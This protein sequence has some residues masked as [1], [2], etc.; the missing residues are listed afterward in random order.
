MSVNKSFSWC[1]VASLSAYYSPVIRGQLT[2][3]V[4]VSL[5]FSILLLLD[6]GEMAQVCIFTLSWTIIP[7]MFVFA[8]LAFVRT[9]DTRIIE[10]MIPASALEKFIFY[11]VYLLIVVPVAVYALPEL[12]ILLYT[13]IPAIQTP[14]VMELVSL[15]CNGFCKILFVNLLSAIAAS[16]TCLY[17]V[18]SARTSRIIKGI[19]SVFGVQV[20]IGILG[21]F[22]GF[23]AAFRQFKAGVKDGMRGDLS[24]IDEIPRAD[25]QTILQDMNDNISYVLVVLGILTV[26]CLL[27]LW[28]N[29]RGLKKRNL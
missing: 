24:Q 6:V 8:P 4:A 9:G 25:V 16:V 7:F 21:A 23:S 14:G 20:A 17:V 10:R 5:M 26:Y 18:M 12:S 3:Y 19:L 22:Y 27:M 28:L 15:H 2:L 11:I 13:K 1:R 29:Y